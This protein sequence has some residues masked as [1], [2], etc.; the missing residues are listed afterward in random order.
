MRCGRLRL[1]VRLLMDDLLYEDKLAQDYVIISRIVWSPFQAEQG[2]GILQ[3]S[4]LGVARFRYCVCIF[5]SFMRPHETLHCDGGAR[6]WNILLHHCR[7]QTA[8][9]GEKMLQVFIYK[10]ISNISHCAGSSTESFGA[11]SG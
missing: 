4:T 9:K 5:N 2:G 8:E 10:F 3:L 7:D 1:M 6:S 11:S